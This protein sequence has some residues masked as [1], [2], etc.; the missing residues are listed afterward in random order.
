VRFGATPLV[1]HVFGSYA[2]SRGPTFDD[3]LVKSRFA[4]LGAGL[5]VTG[6]WAA[7][8]LGASAALEL[9][10]RRVDV[11]YVGQTPSATDAPLRLR[12]S[13]S[14]PAEGTFGG[15]LGAAFRIPT[16]ESNATRNFHLAAPTVEGELFAG[17]EVRL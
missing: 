13:L 9:A 12:G 14:Y 1:A 5:G 8:D 3:S 15:I 4:M 11:S 2:A 16:G 7:L 10:Y 6:A 17:L